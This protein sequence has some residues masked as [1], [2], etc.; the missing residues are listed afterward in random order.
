MLRTS[1]DRLLPAA[2]A[3]A[4]K[5][6]PG[7]LRAIDACVRVRRRDRPQSVAELRSLLLASPDVPVGAEAG[8]GGEARRTASAD[9]GPR[10][11]RYWASAAMVLAVVGGAYGGLEYTRWEAREQGRSGTGAERRASEQGERQALAAQRRVD[12]EALAR[13]AEARR[14]ADEERQRQDAE[15]AAGEARRAEEARQAEAR[16]QADADAAAKK[17]QEVARLALIR[18]IQTE[19]SRVGCDPGPADGEWG[20]RAR[21]ALVKFGRHANV[22]LQADAPTDA[23][24][25]QIVAR[26]GR[27]CPLQCGPEQVPSGDRC[28]QRPARRPATSDGP[29]ASEARKAQPAK[30]AAPPGKRCRYVR[31]YPSSP[32]YTCD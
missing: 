16:R 13:E 18:S 10:R 30:E 20:P 8:R 7:F 22:A 31:R 9:A 23:I 12:Q 19:L 28:L 29:A 1:D 32:V 11:A 15:R 21:E 2:K 17:A 6:S 25:Q 14:A 26:T 24:L 4:G 27:V 5:Y 3:A